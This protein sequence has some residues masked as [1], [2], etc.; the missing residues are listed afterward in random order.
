[1]LLKQKLNNI[2]IPKWIPIALLFIALI[3][4]SD[5]TYITVNHYMNKI[6][7][8]TLSSC[9]TVLNSPYANILGNP[10]SLFGAIYYLL[11]IIFVFA[12]LDTKKEIFLRIPIML[13]V[14]GFI[15]SLWFMFVMAFIIKAYCQYCIFSALSSAGI[16]IVSIYTFKKYKLKNN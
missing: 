15:F 14:I 8:C 7:P 4:F 13:S 11:I 3:G 2:I 9:E 12:Y 6:P 10:V 1:M 5:A 16:F